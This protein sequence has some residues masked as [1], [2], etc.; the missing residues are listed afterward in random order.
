MT[1][2]YSK[3][4]G[5]RIEFNEKICGDMLKFVFDVAMKDGLIK[6]N[7]AD[8][9]LLTCVYSIIDM[10]IQLIQTDKFPKKV[11]SILSCIYKSFFARK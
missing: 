4:R 11:V 1:N 9:E 6:M 8:V 3:L 7:K 5:L 2:L 10:S